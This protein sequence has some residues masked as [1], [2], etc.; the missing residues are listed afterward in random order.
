[1]E[2]GEQFVIT[3][4]VVGVSTMPELCAD[5]W[6]TMSTEVEVSY[7]ALLLFK[8]GDC[9]RSSSLA[10]LFSCCILCCL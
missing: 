2:C 1:M 8:S 4:M 9:S 7:F 6:G 10:N 3:L 5:N